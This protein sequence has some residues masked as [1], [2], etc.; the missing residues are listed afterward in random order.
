ML[1]L[2]KTPSWD[3]RAESLENGIVT[4][5]RFWSS[6]L[7]VAGRKRKACSSLVLKRGQAGETWSGDGFE[8][9]VAK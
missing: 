8:V 1:G 2:V 4:C 7:P 3:G 6:W 9:E 5:Q